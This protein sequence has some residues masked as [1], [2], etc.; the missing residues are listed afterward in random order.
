MRKA[1]ILSVCL[2]LF[3]VGN[4]TTF[5]LKPGNLDMTLESSWN[6]APDGSG[7]DAQSGD[8]NDASHFWDLNGNS[9]TAINPSIFSIS[10]GFLNTGAAVV[11]D[12][13]DMA[14]SGTID[15]TNISLANSSGGTT[16][17]YAHT[18]SIEG[19]P[20]TYN[21]IVML[22]T[23]Q[24]V[25][26]DG[27]ITVGD[28]ELNSGDVLDM[29]I[30]TLSIG[31]L[32]SLLGSQPNAIIKTASTAV[33]LQ[34]TGGA[35]EWNTNIEYTGGANQLVSSTYTYKSGLRIS[36][37]GTKLA[38]GTLTVD[39]TLVTNQ[40][41]DMGAN[42]LLGTLTNQ[43]GTGTLF[44]QNT[45]ALPIPSGKSWSQVTFNHTG[46]Q[47]IPSGTFGTL[48]VD[49]TGTKSAGGD[50]TVNSIL[51]FGSSSNT[52]DMVTHQLSGGPLTVSFGN[53][54]QVL[55]QN[56]S[57]TPLP[58]GETWPSGVLVHFDA[59][60][61]QT[62]PGGTY[63]GGI[64]LSAGGTK[65]AAGNITTQGIIWSAGTIV[66]DMSTHRLID[67][68]AYANIPQVGATPT[69]RTSF[70]GDFPIPDNATWTIFTMIFESS[71]T[72]KV[73]VGECTNLTISGGTGFSNRKV[74]S[75]EADISGTLTIENNC[76][77]ASGSN[78]I[79]DTYQ[80]LG[81][82][83]V[84]GGGTFSTTYLD[85][86]DKLKDP[87]PQGLDWSSLDLFRYDNNAERL[88]G[89]TF[90]EILLNGQGNNHFTTGNITCAK[91]STTNED[92]EILPGTYVIADE[93]SLD[94]TTSSAGGIFLLSDN[95]GYGQLEC[96][97][98]T[99]DGINP[100]INKQI[101]VSASPSE[102]WVDMSTALVGGN[103]ADFAEPGAQIVFDALGTGTAFE[104]D[105]TV[106][107]WT[108]SSSSGNNPA[109]GNR[110]YLATRDSKIFLRS[111]S[112]TVNVESVN[113]QT[114]STTRA[115]NYDNGQNTTATF[116]G[117]TDLVDTEG[118]NFIANPFLANY[119]WDAAH[120]S[121]DALIRKVYYV[122]NGTNY[123]S[124][125]TSG[126]GGAGQYIAPGQG[127]WI[128]VESTWTPGN[129]FPLDISNVDATG[130]G[131]FLKTNSSEDHLVIQVSEENGPYQDQVFMQFG[132][133]FSDEFEPGFDA[134]HLS[135]G[136]NV[137][138]LF[139]I[140]NQGSFSTFATSDHRK[141]Y[142][143]NFKDSEDNQLLK[144]SA[145]DEFLFA[146]N[147]VFI[148]DLKT[149]VI[150]ELSNDGTYEFLNDTKY[151]EERFIIHFGK[152]LSDI[153][154][155]SGSQFFAYFSKDGIT[156]NIHSLQQSNID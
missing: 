151:K 77:L 92:L 148:E 17:Q 45:S 136:P 123:V 140:G 71:G 31:V 109:H 12:N 70:S 50:L 132:T 16:V 13:V 5:Y 150:T 40:G 125:N 142:T 110:V 117:G 48:G 78:N 15:A 22:V 37:T 118:W 52:L 124:R 43:S 57:A 11:L 68:G 128:Q 34:I 155:E 80:L 9:G 32:N 26:A 100:K 122:W 156:I 30:H 76:W 51:A 60:A 90:S 36:G 72:Q 58:S 44:I 56:T 49:G 106:S 154:L 53:S 145:N 112:G 93:V 62:I 64:T 81:S 85:S 102:R 23:P 75:R 2:C 94:G 103:L 141:S 33:A 67:E 89:G 104:W 21:G 120:G 116:V 107:N 28:I 115:M 59:N 10:G 88:V 29:G 46:N 1:I 3:F 84:A 69:L 24:T 146:H 130:S 108:Q 111:G 87:V 65:T 7:T 6:D 113:I 25:V 127:F 121:L 38:N 4:S 114:T 119:D 41:L 99:T 74:L 82:F 47:T 138:N 86:P 105:A 98:L 39:G 152:K 79:V 134:L 147:Y 131:S 61:D 144:F 129:T 133:T 83:T 20:G 143:L 27:N 18:G 42:Q 35:T 66:L 137:P 19:I 73:N 55:T 135:N 153:P 91:L 101:Y 149:G 97:L 96:P 54:H 8:F 95:T 14:F 139:I 126:I 63:T